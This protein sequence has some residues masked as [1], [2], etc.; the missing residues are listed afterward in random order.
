MAIILRPFTKVK[1]KGDFILPESPIAWLQSL[2]G[3]IVLDVPG[4]DARRTRVVSTLLHANEPSGFIGI[5]R[6]LRAW[7]AAVNRLQQE[8]SNNPSR[9]FLSNPSSNPP[10]N[11]SM[12][13]ASDDVKSTSGQ[14]RSLRHLSKSL[15]ATNVRF[16]ISSVEAAKELPLFHQRYVDGDAD[17]NRLFSCVAPAS[18]AEYRAAAIKA[19]IHE[20]NPEAVVDLHNTSGIGQPFSVT[21]HADLE[22]QRL[23]SYFCQNMIHTQLRM[24]SLMEQ[25]FGC[26]AVTIECGGVSDEMSHEVAHQ[27]ISSFLNAESLAAGHHLPVAKIYTQPLRVEINPGMSLS[28]ANELNLAT[29][30][31]LVQHIEQYNLGVTGENTLIGWSKHPELPFTVRTES[32]EFQSVDFLTCI[33]SE[34]RTTQPIRVFMATP[35]ATIAKKDCLFYAVLDA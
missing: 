3:P 30:V 20:V 9:T 6:W 10:T 16:I 4:R 31:T 12:A 21:T 33:D 32:G 27:G 28:Y 8:S 15:P 1:V 17:L 25:D 19:Y 18:E 14:D 29:D 13:S 34:I 24:G 2:E 23:A 35:S 22:Q 7:L 5:H 26:P 11:A